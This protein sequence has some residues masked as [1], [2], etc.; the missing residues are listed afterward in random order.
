MPETE[1]AEKMI[2]KRFLGKD[3]CSD[4][5]AGPSLGP[6]MCLP[7]LYAGMPKR[8]AWAIRG[9]LVGP[10][11][12]LGEALAVD[13]HRP[14]TSRLGPKRSGTNQGQLKYDGDLVA[15]FAW[16]V[17]LLPSWIPPE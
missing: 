9:A 17:I 12:W 11:A 14:P 13:F 5:V 3:L 8:W 16:L 15:L 6:I 2:H 1:F 4:I 7:C 10:R